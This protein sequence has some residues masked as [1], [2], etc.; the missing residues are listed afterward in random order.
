MDYKLT[1]CVCTLL[2]RYDSFLKDCLHELKK[3]I[4]PFKN[5]VELLVHLD[6]RNRLL[7]EKRNEMLSCAKGEY[8]VFVD[9][10]DVL[11]E[12]YISEILKATNTGVD[13]ITFIVNV[14]INGGKYKPCHY[15]LTYNNDYNTD[16]AYFRLPKHICA[17][18]KKLALQTKYKALT[19]GEDS[20]Y[21]KR[22]KPIL[23]SELIINEVLYNYNYNIKTTTTRN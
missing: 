22:L 6:N 16:E 14:S 21:S 23:K 10:D 19:F 7:G 12:N 17:V 9:D 1:I 4:E 5:E 13:V 20:D 15:S 18:K 2:E 8:I 3:Q 11:N